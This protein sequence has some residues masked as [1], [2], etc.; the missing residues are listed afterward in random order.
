M[1]LTIGQ[2]VFFC[3]I[4]LCAI[5]GAIGLFYNDC[6][7]SG[8]AVLLIGAGIAIGFLLYTNWWNTSTA[9]GARSYKDYES[10]LNNGLDRTLKIY[11]EDG[12]MI[13]S[14]EGKI[15]IEDNENYILFE[16]ENGKRHIIYYGIQDTVIIEEK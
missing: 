7:G 11:A 1:A 13:Y 14:Y 16:D 4:L 3:I 9:S 15:D 2:W 6:P 8:L 5:L 12:R 10:N